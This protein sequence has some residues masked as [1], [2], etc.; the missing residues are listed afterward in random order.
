[1]P[2]LQPIIHLLTDEDDVIMALVI[3]MTYT[4]CHLSLGWKRE[5]VAFVSLTEREQY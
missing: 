1:M 4:R 2:A 3:L 5:D